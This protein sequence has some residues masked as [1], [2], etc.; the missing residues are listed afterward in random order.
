M[1]G[2]KTDTATLTAT[3][4]TLYNA[5][6]ANY[7][8]VDAVKDGILHE[9]EGYNFS[10]NEGMMLF[11]HRP[12]HEPLK[13]RYEMKFKDF[14]TANKYGDKYQTNRVSGSLRVSSL[15]KEDT[16]RHEVTTK[17]NDYLQHIV[18][19]LA[20]DGLADTA[21]ALRLVWNNRG[22]YVNKK[23]LVGDAAKKY[24]ALFEAGAGFVP[25]KIDDGVIYRRGEKE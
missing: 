14:L 22:V 3:S 10:Y 20:K 19:E 24:N 4:N 1:A 5:G 7:V 8:L 13:T 15:L 23:Q 16:K 21:K 17:S 12:L 6:N 25:R 18:A 9:G 2:S 11:N